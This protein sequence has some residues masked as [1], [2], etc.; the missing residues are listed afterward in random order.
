[1]SKFFMLNIFACR[2]IMKNRSAKELKKY[3]QQPTGR[4]APTV[5]MVKILF[6]PP[7]T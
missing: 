3:L 7:T 6:R 2:I 1:M 4:H 5:E